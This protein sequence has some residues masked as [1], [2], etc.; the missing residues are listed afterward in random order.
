[1][2]RRWERTSNLV[3]KHKS[4]GE[5]HVGL[6]PLG[7]VVHRCIERFLGSRIDND[8]SWSGEVLGG[9]HKR[10][11]NDLKAIFAGKVTG[12]GKGAVEQ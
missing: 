1:M 6:P 3:D 10:H 7:I 12:Y 8:G 2:N 5:G 4:V 9:N 11:G